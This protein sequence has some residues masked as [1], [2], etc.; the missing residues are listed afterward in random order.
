MSVANIW[1]HS[2]EFRRR[3]RW[4]RNFTD[5]QDG[6]E[7][8][9]QLKADFVEAFLRLR[10]WLSAWCDQLPMALTSSIQLRFTYCLKHQIS[11]FPSFETTYG[12]YQMDSR[13]CFKSVKQLMSSCILHAAFILA[14]LISFGKG[15]QS[16]KA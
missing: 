3:T 11:D 12:V 13:K 6:Y 1:K 8:I 10:N 16:S 9:S 7:I 15:L 4:L 2:R 5:V 14:F